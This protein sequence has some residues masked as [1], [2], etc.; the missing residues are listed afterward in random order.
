M[1]PYHSRPHLDWVKTLPCCHCGLPADDPH[2]LKI[3]G[4]GKA[5]D[6][7]AVPLCRKCH[8]TVHHEG[9]QLYPQARWMIETLNRAFHEG[10]F[11]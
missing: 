10:R 7:A 3:T 11:R 9:P 2:H 6:F 4:V 5:P 1:K 8:D